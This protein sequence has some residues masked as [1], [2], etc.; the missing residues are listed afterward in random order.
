M[1]GPDDGKYTRDLHRS[2]ASLGM[3]TE[4]GEAPRQQPKPV[5]GGIVY[6]Y[7]YGNNGTLKTENCS[8][9]PRVRGPGADRGGPAGPGDGIRQ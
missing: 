4:E 3:T 7:G 2:L 8:F 5:G 1:G 6:E 9:T